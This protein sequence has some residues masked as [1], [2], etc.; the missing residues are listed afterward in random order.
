MYPFEGDEVYVR[1]CWYVAAAPFEIADGPIERT[2]MSS[3]VALFRMADGTPTAMHGVCPHRYYPLAEGRVVGDALQCNYHGFQFDGRTGSCVKVPFQA[4]SPKQFRQRIYP[5]AEHGGWI[6]IWPGDPALA[7]VALLPPLEQAGLSDSWWVQ[8]GPVL[9]AKG[10]AQLLVE[11]LLDITHLEF[12]HA[13]ALEAKGLLD[14]PVKFRQGP[15][16]QAFATRSTRTPWVPQ[17]YDLLYKEEN[18]FEGLHDALGS[19]W[20]F[21][22]AYLRTG[23][24]IQSIDALETI[25]TS[26]YG[27]F[28]FQ[29][30]V[31]PE[32]P[33]SVH[34]FSG[35]SR[36]YRHD[37]AEFDAI[38]MSIDTAVRNQDVAAIEAV[39]R[40][41]ANPAHLGPELL[42]KSDTPAITVR[43]Q[44][45]DI[46]NLE[47]NRS[48]RSAA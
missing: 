12:L 5:T 6:W 25:D 32:T 16:G 2:I 42:V 10:R 39:E 36:N 47:A 45:Q 20:Y 44:I 23:V 30:F 1:N 26:I 4:A 31:T 17:F 19:T 33:H 38:V 7:D 15:N 28:Y 46:L 13:T 3:P 27:T 14:F 9:H 24:D 43:R 8:V 22:P 21:S 40:N 48:A 11:N 29:H 18:R 35:C 34:Y 41:L 37:D